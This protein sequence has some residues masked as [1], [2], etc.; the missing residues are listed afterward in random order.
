MTYQ[1]FVHNVTD[2]KATD[3]LETNEGYVFIPDI[4]NMLK[5]DLLDDEVMTHA[6]PI[7]ERFPGFIQASRYELLYHGTVIETLEFAVVRN[8]NGAQAIPFYE[9]I[10][11]DEEMPITPLEYRT[12]LL[13]TEQM[14]PNDVEGFDEVLEAAKVVVRAE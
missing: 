9:G 10:T 14:G 7:K 8:D 11:V 1:D 12:C 13:I 5:Y 3:W 6:I 4:D 2:S